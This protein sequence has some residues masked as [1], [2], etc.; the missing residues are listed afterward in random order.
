MAPT[1]KARE[2]QDK[3]QSL[4]SRD[5]RE[6]KQPGFP[7]EGALQGGS[8]CVCYPRRDRARERRGCHMK[9]REEI[10]KTYSKSQKGDHGVV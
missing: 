7:E 9:E 4:K 5:L 8:G 3:V 6:P 2:G 1:P 10:N